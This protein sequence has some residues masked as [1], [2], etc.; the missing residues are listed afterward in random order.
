[1]GSLRRLARNELVLV[2]PAGAPCDPVR[3]PTAALRRWRRIAAAES[4]VPAGAAADR[5]LRRLGLLESLAGRLV[6]A[7]HVRAALAWTAQGEVDGAFVYETD[8][9]AEPRVRLVSR[10]PEEASEGLEVWAALVA[11]PERPP[12]A[13]ALLEFLASEEA[14]KVLRAAGWR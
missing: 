11:R 2:A 1:M 12:E 9:R 5:A 14:V 7:P 4:D 13:A 8:A 10:L 6:R 3:G